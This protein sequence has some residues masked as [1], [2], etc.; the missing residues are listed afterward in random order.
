MQAKPSVKTLNP[1]FGCGPVRKPTGWSLKEIVYEAGRSH[2]SAYG[3]G[4]LE[5]LEDHV[6]Q[7]LN[8]PQNYKVAFLTGS[9]TA[10]MEAGLWNLIGAA[11]LTLFDFDTFANR[12]AD[13]VK[14][15]LKPSIHINHISIEFGQTYAFLDYN[16]ADDLLFC[17]NGSTSGMNMP[18]L[19]WLAENRT[20]LVFCDA[21]S[22]AY[23][24]PLPFEKLDVTAFSF[25][26]GLAAEAGLGCL[27][28]SEK[29][30]NRL[31][32]YTPI[33][34]IP[35]LLRIKDG[36]YAVFQG[37][38]LNTPSMFCI[39]ESIYC[40]RFFNKQLT[41]DYVQNNKKVIQKCLNQTS[42]FKNVVEQE[43]YRSCCTGV[44]QIIDKEFLKKEET[45]QRKVLSKMSHL[46]NDEEIAFDF[47]N[48]PSQ[49]P[50][51]RIWLGSTMEAENIERLFPWLNWAYET[52]RRS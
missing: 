7:S 9:A 4:R 16:P 25:Q 40:H 5:V 45:D 27:I 28:L 15:Q 14:A 34:P 29:A 23:C 6:R 18:S 31:M 1:L 13:D 41:Y 48:H 49:P 36:N 47:I 26:K 52:V 38:L 33:W 24:V 43:A 20:G 19:D 8:I 46:L 39:E 44:F 50:S 30:Y 12:W 17:W 32:S 3:V 11:D 42:F 10:A 37:K 35:R 51:L 2:R 22:A 21:T